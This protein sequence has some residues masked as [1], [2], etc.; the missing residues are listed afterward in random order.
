M[1]K[2]LENIYFLVA[3]QRSGTQLFTSLLN[4]QN[5]IRV[6]GELFHRRHEGRH[7]FFFEKR[8]EFFRE[9]PSLTLPSPENQ[10]VIFRKYFQFLKE[11]LMGNPDNALVVDVKYSSCHHFNTYWQ[12]PMEA[13]HMAALAQGQGVGIVHLI[14]RNLLANYCSS[15]LARANKNW[16]AVDTK[17]AIRTVEVPVDL[18]LQELERRDGEVRFYRDAFRACR[19]YVEVDYET[20]LSPE[21]TISE[22]AVEKLTI[23][24]DRRIEPTLT[25]GTRKTA[26]P[27]SSLISNHDEVRECLEGTRFSHFLD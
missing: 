8:Q 2:I 3:K 6:T 13:P 20:L 5:S 15:L 10:R 12:S 4:Q 18:L 14:R 23:A 25:P 1:G 22:E 7:R 9:D 19:T 16:S 17:R 24:L 26:A 21:N 11:N 27:L